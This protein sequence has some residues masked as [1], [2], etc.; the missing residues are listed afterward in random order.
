MGTPEEETWMF[1]VKPVLT[2]DAKLRPLSAGV[3]FGF[4]E[5]SLAFDAQAEGAESPFR[6][7]VLVSRNKEKK[8]YAVEIT[9]TGDLSARVAF[10]NPTEGGVS[11]LLAPVILLNAGNI[12]LALMFYVNVVNN[13]A[14]AFQFS[15][16]FFE[17]DF[18]PPTS[19][20]TK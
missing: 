19:G 1:S 20:G 6:I 17:V 5:Q 18:V 15:Y 7:E 13:G 10:Y 2:S 14:Q 8:A 4:F 12:A 9:K 3:A 16:Q 11:G